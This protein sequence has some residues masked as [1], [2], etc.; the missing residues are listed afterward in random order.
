MQ[1]TIKLLDFRVLT[2]FIIL[3]VGLI[4]F[5]FYNAFSQTEEPQTLV[6]YGFSIVSTI[7]GMAIV[8]IPIIR[9]ELIRRNILNPSIINV[10]NTSQTLLQQYVNDQAKFKQLAEIVYTGL[11]QD[12]VNS[13][14]NKHRVRLAELE[15][16]LM[17]GKMK[18][19]EFIKVYNELRNNIK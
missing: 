10:L 5:G 6:D 11:P 17:N 8:L 14:E 13:I 15:K 4:S 7:V 16:D 3:G 9:Q 18:F 2:I 1:S 19:D 12:F